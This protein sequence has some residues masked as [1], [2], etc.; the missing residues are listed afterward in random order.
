MLILGITDLKRHQNPLIPNTLLPVFKSEKRSK[1]MYFILNNQ[2][3][4]PICEN[5][6]G[7]IIDPNLD[8][9]NIHRI[10]KVLNDNGF[11]TELYIEF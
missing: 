9:K 1:D 2:H 3:K 11:S 5:Q 8:W 4:T 6:W 7:K 10:L